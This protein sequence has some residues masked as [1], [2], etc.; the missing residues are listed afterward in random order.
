MDPVAGFLD[1]LRVEKSLSPSTIR[2]YANDLKQVTAFLHPV[3]E[4]TEERLL[5]P[6]D[7]TLRTVRSFLSHLS[8]RGLQS[9]SLARKL[10]TLRSFF[11]YL[12]RE[13]VMDS[14]P[15]KTIPSPA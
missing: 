2:A 11:R 9:A 6:A 4:G 15:A 3:A 1:Y 14:N 13:G 5:D 8:V 12:N 10:A 7:F